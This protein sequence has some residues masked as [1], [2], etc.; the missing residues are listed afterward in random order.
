MS[1]QRGSRS[2]AWV[3]GIGLLAAATVVWAA[4][5]D[6]A[7]RQKKIAGA[8]IKLQLASGQLGEADE[9]VRKARQTLADA[10]TTVRE[11]ADRQASI[12][13][14]LE[15]AQPADSRFA[16]A[17]SAHRA[18]A[19]QFEPFKGRPASSPSGDAQVDA[20]YKRLRHAKA[21]FDAAQ[22]EILAA[23]P[24]WKQAAEELREAQSQHAAADAALQ[25]ALSKRA[26]LQAILADAINELAA[27]APA[28]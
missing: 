17:R 21:E 8:R 27:P 3:A 2:T 18:A 14:R 9:A 22:A 7:A 24:L 25:S 20:A 13:K 10:D 28:R 6:D 4:N 11:A 23:S 19:A 12:A 16:R 26:A 5:P 1:R 15:N